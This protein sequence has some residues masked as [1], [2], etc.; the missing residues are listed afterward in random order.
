MQILKLNGF[1]KMINHNKNVNFNGINDVEHSKTTCNREYIGWYGGDFY[2][3]HTCE[4]N[5]NGQLLVDKIDGSGR[6]RFEK[7]VEYRYYDNGALKSKKSFVDRYD[8]PAY[9]DYH[10]NEYNKDGTISRELSKWSDRISEIFYDIAA[11]IAKKE[12][13]KPGMIYD[14]VCNEHRT[15]SVVEKFYRKVKDSIPYRVLGKESNGKII[16]EITNPKILSKI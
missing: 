6:C 4:Y 15:Y 16:K 5:S 8:R 7:L 11:G 2:A 1:G 9:G 14:P 12:V 10:L 13:K 3:N